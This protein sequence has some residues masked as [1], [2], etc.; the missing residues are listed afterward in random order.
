MFNRRRKGHSGDMVYE[1]KSL[2]RLV[3]G[4]RWKRAERQRDVTELKHI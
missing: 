4:K 2:I 1:E 3:V